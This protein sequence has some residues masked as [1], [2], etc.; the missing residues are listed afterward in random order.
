MHRNWALTMLRM[1]HVHGLGSRRSVRCLFTHSWISRPDVDGCAHPDG[2]V[3]DGSLKDWHTTILKLVD[4]T[5]RAEGLVH[6]DGWAHGGSLTEE[7]Y[8]CLYIDGLHDISM[9]GRTASCSLVDGWR[10]LVHGLR[11]ATNRPR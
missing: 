10:R 7:R 11:R 2:L 6:I 9:D 3:H 8:V 4:V 5:S 1:Y